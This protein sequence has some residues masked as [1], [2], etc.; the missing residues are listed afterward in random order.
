MRDA[1][2]KSILERAGYDHVDE[3]KTEVYMSE[4]GGEL[5]NYP[6]KGF[7]SFLL[8]DEEIFKNIDFTDDEKR[9]TI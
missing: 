6:H 7:D 4:H 1:K 8:T 2:V 9:R 5:P 3:V